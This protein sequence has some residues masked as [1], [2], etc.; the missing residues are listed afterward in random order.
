MT[1]PAGWEIAPWVD[2]LDGMV[3]A[4][5]WDT[6]CMLIEDGRSF[7]TFN[8]SAV[9]KDCTGACGVAAD[10][11]GQ[12]GDQYWAISCSRRVLVRWAL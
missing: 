7:S 3:N 2:G 1:M 10:C 5:G 12:D 9:P 4:Q 11:L 8:H 6:H